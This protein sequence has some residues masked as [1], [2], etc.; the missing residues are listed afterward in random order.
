[1]SLFPR[2]S[3]GEFTPLFR[4]LD[5]YDAHVSNRS[6]TTTRFFNPKFDVREEK[7]AYHLDGELPGIDQKDVTIEFSDQSTLVIKGRT[8]RAYA[9]D[10]PEAE[11]KAEGKAEGRAE[12]A[13]DQGKAES[14]TS[15]TKSGDKSVQKPAQPQHKYWVSER[16]IGEFQRTF[17]FPERVDQDGVKASLKNGVLSITVPKAAAPAAKRITIE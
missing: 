3:G 15:V 5:D 17:S 9:G 16:S 4:L 1:M 10:A 11:S 7:D 8:E 12:K 6:G 2:L 13:A 14:S